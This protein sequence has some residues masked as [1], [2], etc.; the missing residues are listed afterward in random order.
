VIAL[1]L[2]TTIVF[3]IHGAVPAGKIETDPQ[4]NA[5]R[6]NTLENEVQRIKDQHDKLIGL[7]IATLTTVVVNMI[8][9]LLTHR[10]QKMNNQG[11]SAK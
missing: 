11:E 1:A 3:W 2:V 9:Y 4:V 7:M 5:Y 8:V 6:I 10:S